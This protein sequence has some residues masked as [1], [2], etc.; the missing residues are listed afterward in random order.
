MHVCCNY[1]FSLQLLLYVY[2]LT[3]RC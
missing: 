1:S 3:G 2:L